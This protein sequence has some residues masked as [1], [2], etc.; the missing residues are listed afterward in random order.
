MN[1]I[2]AKG[3]WLKGHSAPIQLMSCGQII[4]WKAAHSSGFGLFPLG[5][6]IGP[7]LGRRLQLW[8]LLLELC[9]R[10]PPCQLQE[11]VHPQPIRLCQSAQLLGLC[12]RQLCD[13]VLRFDVPDQAAI[14]Q[15]AS[16]ELC[17][18][19]DTE[20]TSS[21]DFDYLWPRQAPANLKLEALALC[22]C[23][24]PMLVQLAKHWHTPITA[25]SSTYFQC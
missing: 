23:T 11:P 5:N 3:T 9:K 2:T 8:L 21:L 16:L 19:A 13:T 22:R 4:K 14:I 12:S 6:G 10:A 18:T 25:C 17:V 24:P 20:M 7:A 1:G 15:P